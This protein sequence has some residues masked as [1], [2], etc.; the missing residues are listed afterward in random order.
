MEN[1]VTPERGP[2]AADRQAHPNG[3]AGSAGPENG[4]AQEG[5]EQ[6][7][8]QAEEMAD[9]LLERAEHYASWLGR[10]VMRLAARVRE[11]A[12]DIWAE[13]EHVSRQWQHA[14]DRAPESGARGQ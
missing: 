12:T 6:A 2:E 8:R 11:E 9:R 13:A 5:R 10:H 14:E 4:R 1:S 3:V 7:L